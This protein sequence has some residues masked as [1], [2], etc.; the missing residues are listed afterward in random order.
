MYCLY[1]YN[2]TFY[3]HNSFYKNIQYKSYHNFINVKLNQVGFQVSQIKCTI[4]KIRK[5]Y[6]KNIFLKKK[7]QINTLKT[8][9]SLLQN[10]YILKKKQENTLEMILKLE[11]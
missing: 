7:K 10:S 2:H 3:L 1:K 11:N 6:I 8:N 9:P 5:E 4:Y